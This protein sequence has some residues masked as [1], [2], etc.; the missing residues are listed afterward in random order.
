MNKDVA[1]KFESYPLHIKQHIF[2]LRSLIYDVANEDSINDL[3]ECLK[4]G[5]PS[6]ITKYGSTLRIDWKAKT[7]NQYA[8][9]FHCKTTLIETFKE[10]YP[11]VFQY[12]GNRA[13]IFVAGEAI[14]TQELK[15]CISL[16]LKYHLVKKL[17]LLGA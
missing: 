6:Y 7:P 2:K 3:D 17:P 1:E 5:E 16:A 14:A 8:L 4:W 10:L 15:H 13:I 11:S 12:S 9:Y